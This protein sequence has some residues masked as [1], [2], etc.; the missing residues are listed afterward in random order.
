MGTRNDDPDQRPVDVRVQDFAS[1]LA[2]RLTASGML[3]D[4]R[5]G[6]RLVV[7]NVQ[8]HDRDGLE[9]IMNV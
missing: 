1:Q 8:I 2:T 9:E 5:V 6:Y 3:G 7:K 4:D